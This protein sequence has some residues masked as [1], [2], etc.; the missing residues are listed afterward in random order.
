MYVTMTDEANDRAHKSIVERK[1]ISAQNESNS[2]Y[3]SE[4]SSNEMF[5]LR[6]IRRCKHSRSIILV[7]TLILIQP[8]S[9]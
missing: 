7:R 8:A 4:N 5:G 3:V 1:Y 9:K 2:L 6:I